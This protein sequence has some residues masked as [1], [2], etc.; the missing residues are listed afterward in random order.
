MD[1]A[2]LGVAQELLRQ[3]RLAYPGLPLQRHRSSHALDSLL[4]P[5]G[6]PRVL[7]IPADEARAAQSVWQPQRTARPGVAPHLVHSGYVSSPYLILEANEFGRW[8]GPELL[9]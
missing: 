9:L 7:R 4:K 3:P 5:C 6:E 1:G 2:F 8:S